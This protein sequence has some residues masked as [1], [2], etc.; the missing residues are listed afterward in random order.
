[1]KE[2]DREC[3]PDLKSIVTRSGGAI[4]SP[5]PNLV[6]SIMEERFNDS[7]FV[8]KV[9]GKTEALVRGGIARFAIDI[10]DTGKTAK[11]NKLLPKPYFS[12]IQLVYS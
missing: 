2:E 4:I 9:F 12:H 11:R 10:V 3:F 8:R 5:Y 6:K 7:R 1:V